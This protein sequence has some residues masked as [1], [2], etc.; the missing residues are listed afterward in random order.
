MGVTVEQANTYFSTRLGAAAFW[1][2]GAAKAAALAT[3]ESMLA[4]RYSLAANPDAVQ[5][6]GVCEQALF[7]L[8]NPDWEKRASLRAQGVTSA[9]V[10]KEGYDAA[11]DVLPIAPMAAACL[12]DRATGSLGIAPLT[13]DEIEE[14]D[15]FLEAM[16]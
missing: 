1:T 9:G 11:A 10:V 5:V 14:A 7:L 8:Q 13:R 15:E 3:A 16:K 2:T 12:S 4:G 6:R